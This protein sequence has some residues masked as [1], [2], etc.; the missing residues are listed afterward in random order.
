MHKARPKMDMIDHQTREA[1]LCLRQRLMAV[2]AVLP[3]SRDGL[4]SLCPYSTTNR[5]VA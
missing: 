4:A 3:S 2:R 1:V 5:S